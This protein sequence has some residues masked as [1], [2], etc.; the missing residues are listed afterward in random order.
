MLGNQSAA[1]QLLTEAAKGAPA[2][3]EVRLHAALAAAAMNRFVEAEAHLK[4]ALRRAP[5][6]EQREDVQ[7]LR[8]R[9]AR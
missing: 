2:N 5:A 6:Y 3:P 8:R 9:F 7:Q 4:E 1:Y